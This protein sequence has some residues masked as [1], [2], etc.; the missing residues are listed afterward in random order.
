MKSLSVKANLFFLIALAQYAYSAEPVPAASAGA[1]PTNMVGAR[2]EF[3]AL[4]YD[5]GKLISG[6]SVRHDFIFT[7]TGDA[8]LEISGVHPS[9]G[10][11]TAGTWSNRVEPGKTGTIPLVFN[12]GHF[13]G[14][15]A[16][17]ASVLCNDKSHAQVTLQIRGTIWKPIEVNPPSAV[18]NVVADSPSNPPATVTIV[19][20]LPEPIT[21]SDPISNNRA[22]A[23]EIKTNQPGK[24]F[25]LII[26]PVPPLRQGTAQGIITVRTSSTNV[27]SIDVNVLAVIQPAWVVTPQ[28]ITL[29]AGPLGSA[30]PRAISI[31]NNA[32][33][34]MTLSEPAVNANDVPVEMKEVV[35]GHQFTLTLTFPAGFQVAQGEQV[36]LTVKTSDPKYPVIN[37]PVHQSLPADPRDIGL[38]TPHRGP[39]PPAPPASQPNHTP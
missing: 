9:C 14:P 15:V 30:L 7:N 32:A 33:P 38:P 39:M 36:G 1:G 11:T 34:L 17:T 2:I 35:P 12:S 8:V 25:Q 13:N 10:C 3:D 21:L 29:P 31:R 6:L 27:P 37:V 22:F 20:S 24:E 26:R 28:E 16:K 4:V 23:A 18:L 5:F 19:S